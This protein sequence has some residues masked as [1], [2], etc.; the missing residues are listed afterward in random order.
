M[1]NI[2][3]FREFIIQPSLHDLILN[4]PDAEELLVFTCA[5]ESLGGTYIKQ[6]KDQH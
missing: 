1:L 6:L 3:Q 5:N 4:S 2:A